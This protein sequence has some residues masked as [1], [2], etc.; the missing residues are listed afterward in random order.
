M[1]LEFESIPE[2]AAR[3]RPYPREYLRFGIF[4]P[5]P[6]LASSAIPNKMT[7]TL[8]RTGGNDCLDQKRDA[9]KSDYDT[10]IPKRAPSH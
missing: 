10:R 7:A 1:L 9:D 6:F 8:V 5:T 2:A 4:S 3:A